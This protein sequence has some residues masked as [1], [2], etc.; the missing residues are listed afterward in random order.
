M[1]LVTHISRAS[2]H[3]E[4]CESID[5]DL[6][7]RALD[8]V[9]L[10]SLSLVP[11]VCDEWKSSSGAP[12]K[13]NVASDIG[14]YYYFFLVNSG[15]CYV[16][17]CENSYPKKLALMYVA[18]L[19]KQFD[20]SF[21]KEVGSARTRYSFQSFDTFIGQTRKLYESSSSAAVQG[22]DGGMS[23]VAG[24]LSDVHRIMADNLRDIIQR[25]EK[26]SVVAA[27]SEDLFAES[28]KYEK[29]AKHLSSLMWWRKYGT[30]IVVLVLVVFLVAARSYIF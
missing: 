8:K 12:L 18:E 19:Q 22:A 7:N 29:Q 25:G 2:D 26:I 16:A 30:I 27:R 6:E 5:T 13:V 14:P 21:A 10:Q 24:E 23:K 17:L 20:L 15:V 1:A 11:R 9:R 4:L 3:L 28:L